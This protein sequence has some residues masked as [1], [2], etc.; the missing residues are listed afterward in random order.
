MIILTSTADLT[1]TVVVC[2]QETDGDEH[3]QLDR[4]PPERA[5]AVAGPR[6]HPDGF[7][8]PA[9]FIHVLSRDTQHTTHYYTLHT[10]NTGLD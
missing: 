1:A 3:A 10:V 4:D 8:G 7:P 2:S 9:V 5:A 6:A